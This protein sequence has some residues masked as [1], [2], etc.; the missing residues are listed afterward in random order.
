MFFVDSCIAPTV[1]MVV[2]VNAKEEFIRHVTDVGK[3]VLCCKIWADTR[4]SPLYGRDYYTHGGKYGPFLLPKYHLP[5]EMEAFVENLDFFY[6]ADY[7]GQEL[8]GTIWYTDGSW[9]T[10]F[11][12]DGSEWW[13]H[14]QRPE[15]PFDL[16]AGYVAKRQ[17]G[18]FTT[19]KL[20]TVVKTPVR[21]L[22]LESTRKNRYLRCLY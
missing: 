3:R 10:R 1:Q 16:G 7:G 15:I 5:R 18:C 20:K 12:Y 6:N 19:L 4:Y 21:Q 11:E 2:F 14:H 13:K 22:R 9:S 17:T 8:Y